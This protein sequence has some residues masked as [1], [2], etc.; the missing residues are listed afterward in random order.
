MNIVWKS[1]KWKKNLFRN[2][3]KHIQPTSKHHYVNHRES[4]KTEKSEWER[5][6]S[7]ALY[8]LHL[9]FYCLVFKI[10]IT[11]YNL[12]FYFIFVQYTILRE[13]NCSNGLTIN[14]FFPTKKTSTKWISKFICIDMNCDGWYKLVSLQI[15]YIFLLFFHFRVQFYSCFVH[16]ID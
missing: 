16:I 4:W 1:W 13:V 8:G 11:A 14:L 2:T 10:F 7:S 12:F 6:H 5:K 9:N 3:K 15:F